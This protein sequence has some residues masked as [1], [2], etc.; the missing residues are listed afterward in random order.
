MVEE[1]IPKSPQ[2]DVKPVTESESATATTVTEDEKKITP[3]DNEEPEKEAPEKE[4]P[5]NKE[6]ERGDGDTSRAES[7]HDESDYEDN[8]VVTVPK[9]Q[10]HTNNYH[11]YRDR[12][13]M[14]GR[15]N[16]SNINEGDAP[17]NQSHQVCAVFFF[18][19]LDSKVC[20]HFLT[21]NILF[22]I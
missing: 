6:S 2:S 14:N 7:P 1:V 12:Q 18:F 21:R 4:A 15:Y 9:P 13:S 19:I 3:P 22:F 17:P 10:T 20:Q 8:I 5:E 16:R 11:D